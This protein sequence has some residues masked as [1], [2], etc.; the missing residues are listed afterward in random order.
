[1]TF[2]LSVRDDI[3]LQKNIWFGHAPYMPGATNS[4]AKLLH[5]LLFPNQRN[6]CFQNRILPVIID[7][8]SVTTVAPRM[9]NSRLTRTSAS[10]LQDS[11]TL[12]QKN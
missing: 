8:L 7:L 2:G 12:V 6:V 9:A 10:D 11:Q 5:I 4:H 3:Y 1:M